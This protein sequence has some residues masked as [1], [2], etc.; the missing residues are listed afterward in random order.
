M[1]DENIIVH[2]VWIGGSLSLLEQL[3][4]KLLQSH[5][6]EVHL[7]SYNPISNVPEGTILN[8]AEEILPRSTIFTYNGKPLH[9][10]PNGGIGSLSHWSDQFQL[11]LLDKKGGIYIQ[12]DV[13]CIKPLNFNTEYAFVEHKPG[14]VAAYVMKCP[15]S[16]AFAKVGYILLSQ[17]INKNTMSDLD[18]DSSMRIMGRALDKIIPDN[19]K[20]RLS[21]KISLDL[22]CRKNGP[23]FEDVLISSEVAMIHWS[24]AT[25]RELKNNPIKN[26]VYYKLLQRVNLI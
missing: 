13:A 2:V 23:F 14:A 12:L 15:Q 16:N 4:I 1:L 22:G 20:Y 17:F 25:V 24:N 3:T 8:N 6:H 26:S 19:N 18:W 21:P 10:I 11:S 7:W 5:G 9:G